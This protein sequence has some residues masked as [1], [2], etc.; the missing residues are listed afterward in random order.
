MAPNVRIMM[1]R[2]N[3]I[4]INSWRQNDHGELGKSSC[5]MAVD[6]DRDLQR[7]QR[8]YVDFLD[9]DV[10]DWCVGAH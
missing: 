4:R 6:V 8:E 1:S 10:S 5:L 7:V 9:D 2:I 3:H